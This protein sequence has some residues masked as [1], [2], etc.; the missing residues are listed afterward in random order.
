MTVGW[1]LLPQWCIL[2][3]PYCATPWTCRGSGWRFPSHADCAVLL[4]DIWN[5][6]GNG[7]CFEYRQTTIGCCCFC[8]SICILW[9]AYQL[10]NIFFVIR[11]LTVYLLM[12]QLFRV[13]A[14]M[15][16]NDTPMPPVCCILMYNGMDILICKL[17]PFG[18]DSNIAESES[19]Y[20]MM[21][22]EYYCALCNELLTLLLW[23]CFVRSWCNQSF[24]RPLPPALMP[25]LGI[26]HMSG[27]KCQW[28]NYLWWYSIDAFVDQLEIH[29]VP[30]VLPLG[31]TLILFSL[32]LCFKS[33][34]E[35]RYSLCKPPWSCW[36]IL[37][38]YPLCNSR[39]YRL[40]CRRCCE[41]WQLWNAILN[42]I[43]VNGIIPAEILCSYVGDDSY[44][45]TGRWCDIQFPD[46]MHY[47]MIFM[48][49]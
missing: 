27:E 25:W 42:S 38:L 49:Q 44:R 20:S 46:D 24:E 32:W 31:R 2:W 11:P 9:G 21:H 41:T 6:V 45:T 8:G 47:P 14:R 40:Y 5:H 39:T 28:C 35:C 4:R 43:A 48:L 29:W 22:C 17:D 36:I 23:F 3:C 33:F 10:C 18:D 7:A 26:L 34:G 30:D 13:E 15:D 12:G 37:G 16:C 19:G 1:L